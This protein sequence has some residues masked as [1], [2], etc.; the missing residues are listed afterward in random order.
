MDKALET[1]NKIKNDDAVVHIGEAAK[2]KGELSTPYSIGLPIFD[3][4][5]KGG[6]RAGDLIVITGI[7]G[8]GKTSVAQNLTVNLSKNA[9]Q[10]IWFSYEVI[11]DNLYAK[12]KEMGVDDSHLLVYTP[13]HNTTGNLEWV[14]EKIVEAKSKYGARFVFI[15][16]IDYLSPKNVRSGDQYRMVLRQICQE[17][18][19]MAIELELTI[20]LIAHVKK[21]QGR[22][23]E[24]QDL[25]ESG[26]LYQLADAVFGVSRSAKEEN[27]HT[28]IG[29]IGTLRM[30]KNR[31]TGKHVTMDFSLQ[32]NVMI[33]FFQD[34]APSAP[35][36][37][38][39]SPIKD[40]VEIE[41]VED[42]LPFSYAR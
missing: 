24:M 42:T 33:P 27:K 21:V 36:R 15:D 1:Y 26:A 3:E 30:L 37:R 2:N 14:Q 29:D 31:I 20:F 23:I 25:A 38:Y 8:M 9:N 16:H 10:S 13:K 4:A 35:T 41:V 7:S 28:L 40:E 11:M 5:L 18:K 6:V 17:L 12:F 22:E 19:T 39:A 34:A 32:N